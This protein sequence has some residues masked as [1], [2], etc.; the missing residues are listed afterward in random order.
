MFWYLLQGVLQESNLCEVTF[1]NHELPHFALLG[2]VVIPVDSIG[3]I[4]VCLDRD[5]QFFGNGDVRGL[6][7]FEG[8]ESGLSASPHSFTMRS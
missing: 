1:L 2:V 4:T 8:S 6:K 5:T 7:T 3:A